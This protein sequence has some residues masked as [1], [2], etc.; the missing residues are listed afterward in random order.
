M[1]VALGAI[2]LG[3]DAIRHDPT[4]PEG[5]SL[6]LTKEADPTPQPLPEPQSPSPPELQSPS[7]SEPLSPSASEPSPATEQ[8]SA[9]P[10]RPGTGEETDPQERLYT[11]IWANVREA[12]GPMAPVVTVLQPGEPVLVDSLSEE[13]YRVVA[14]GQKLGYVYRELVDTVRPVTRN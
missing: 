11:T 7:P 13:W 2:Y 4:A 1:L 3:V 10:E 9:A 8:T 14:D 5:A 12:R 6:P